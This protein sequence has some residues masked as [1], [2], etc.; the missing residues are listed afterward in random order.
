MEYIYSIYIKKSLISSSFERT[1]KNMIKESSY[2]EKKRSQSPIYIWSNS[3]RN[4]KLDNDTG[5]GGSGWKKCIV[6]GVQ[7][8]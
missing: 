8:I 2:R 7:N 4:Y 5:T 1:W 3:I 6:T